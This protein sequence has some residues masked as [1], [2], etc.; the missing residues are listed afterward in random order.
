MR[1]LC[2]NKYGM[3]PI[4][5]AP[6]TGI[7]SGNHLLHLN[8]FSVFKNIDIILQQMILEISVTFFVDNRVMRIPLA[9]GALNAFLSCFWVEGV[10]W[11]SNL[12]PSRLS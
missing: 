4:F 3:V 12:L 11:T 6:T 8:W 2:L 7:S 9:Y 10:L 5:P 1:L